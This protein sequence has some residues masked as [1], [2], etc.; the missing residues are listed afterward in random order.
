M[1]LLTLKEAAAYARCSEMT[2]R[3][4]WKHGV[5]VLYKHAGLHTTR[6]DIDAWVKSSVVIP[7]IDPRI[8]QAKNAAV[9]PYFRKRQ[10][11]AGARQ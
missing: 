10:R 5:L 3:R 4:A 9:L 7:V 8:K 11:S 6:E 2:L 1:E